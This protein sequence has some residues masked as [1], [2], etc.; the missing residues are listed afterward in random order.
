MLIS[1]FCSKSLIW[2]LVSFPSLLV[3]CIFFFISLYTA[4]TSS[5]ILRPYSTISVSILITSV[6]NCASDRLAISS[7]L[8]VFLKLWS[9]LSLGPYS[10]T[11]CTRYVVS[12]GA[13]GVW[14]GGAT[15]FSPL[16]CCLWGRGL[17]VNNATCL[18][19]T[20]LS[21]TSVSILITSVLNSAHDRLALSSSLSSFFWSFDLFFHLGHISLSQHTCYIVRGEP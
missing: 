13:L 14:Q 10:L 15:H 8:S 19:L 4:F 6:L 1:S 5:C 12:G 7:S 17:R 11:Q 18:A 9:V 3:P 20:P 2:V 16:W 21:V